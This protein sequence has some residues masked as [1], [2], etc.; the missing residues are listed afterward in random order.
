LLLRTRA[1]FAFDVRVGHVTSAGEICELFAFTVHVDEKVIFNNDPS[2]WG[3]LGCGPHHPLIVEPVVVSLGVEI[4]RRSPER[5]QTSDLQVLLPLWAPNSLAAAE[6][7]LGRVL[8]QTGHLGVIADLH[9]HIVSAWF[10]QECKAL[11][12]EL[13]VVWKPTILRVRCINSL[14]YVTVGGFE[15]TDR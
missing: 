6:N 7:H 13:A 3:C 1:D 14:L 8:A 10:K 12:R 5:V 4:F 2:H 15:D 11:V 9:F